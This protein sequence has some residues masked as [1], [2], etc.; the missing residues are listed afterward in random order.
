MTLL[1]FYGSPANSNSQFDRRVSY[2]AI[3]Y[4]S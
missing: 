4:L 3:H 2:F 1:C